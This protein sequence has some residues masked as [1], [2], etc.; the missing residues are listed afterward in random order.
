MT[1]LVQFFLILLICSMVCFNLSNPNIAAYAT[2]TPR[3]TAPTTM[4]QTTAIPIIWHAARNASSVTTI[5][6]A[7]ARRFVGSLPQVSF[8]RTSTMMLVTTIR[9][10]TRGRIMAVT[11]GMF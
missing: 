1:E 11:P 10:S 3:M 9:T 5:A 6:T 4:Y 7:N 2:N 8:F